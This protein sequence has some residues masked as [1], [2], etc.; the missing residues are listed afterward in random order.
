MNAIKY[1]SIPKKGL[2]LKAWNYFISKYGTPSLM[3]FYAP[4]G[5]HPYWIANVLGK[6]ETVTP[7]EIKAT[8]SKLGKNLI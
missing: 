1:Y 8:F 7:E 3:T 2:S 5:G 6:I 4:C